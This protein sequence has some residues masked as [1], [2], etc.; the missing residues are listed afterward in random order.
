MEYTCIRELSLQKYDVDGSSIENEYVEI[1]VGDVYRKDDETKV[2]LIAGKDAIR[3]NKHEDENSWIEI[4]KST[5]L[6]YFI[7]FN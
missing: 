2:N 5:L 7:R 6:H 1:K 4:E 3:L